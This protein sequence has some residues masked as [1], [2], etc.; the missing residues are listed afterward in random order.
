MMEKERVDAVLRRHSS[1][2]AGRG[3]IASKGGNLANRG[4]H[5]RLKGQSRTHGHH[6]TAGLVAQV[7]CYYLGAASEQRHVGAA[8]CIVASGPS[9]PRQGGLGAGCGGAAHPWT[10]TWKAVGS[11][12]QSL[13]TGLVIDP[14]PSMS[15]VFLLLA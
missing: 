12:R 14:V 6:V 11:N 5:A 13:V 7:G 10:C 15:C 4:P 1:K 9:G 8:R 3:A 2:R